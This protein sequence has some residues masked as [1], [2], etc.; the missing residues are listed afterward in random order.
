MQVS[1]LGFLEFDNKDEFLSLKF[2]K[3]TA[4]QTIIRNN[5][6]ASCP[7]GAKIVMSLVFYN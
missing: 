5:P 3:W 6:L 2:E 1:G 7:Y 4:T